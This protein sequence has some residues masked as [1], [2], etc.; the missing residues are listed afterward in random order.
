MNRRQMNGAF[1]DALNGYANVFFTED[2]KPA[3]AITKTRPE[4]RVYAEKFKCIAVVESG[5]EIAGGYDCREESFDPGWM[6]GND[7]DLF[8]CEKCHTV[9][10]VPGM[11]IYECPFC[12][13]YDG[14]HC[15]QGNPLS[16]TTDS[17]GVVVDGR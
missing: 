11:T 12:G 16:D 15:L 1:I 14:D 5:G 13:A 10:P 8:M 2:G 9:W 7:F 6:S 4:A 3:V 17:I